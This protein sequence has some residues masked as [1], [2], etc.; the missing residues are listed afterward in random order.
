MNLHNFIK[1]SKAV[2][3]PIVL[4]RPLIWKTS[5]SVLHRHLKL[6]KTSNRLV[7]GRIRSIGPTNEMLF[8]R[9]MKV[10][11]LKD[12]FKHTDSL[13]ERIH[14]KLF[15][16]RNATTAL[17]CFWRVPLIPSQGR[18]QTSDIC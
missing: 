6:L 10:N 4:K 12:L 16:E 3:M 14:S 17:S 18:A 7:K 5:I 2:K 1:S 13:T 11:E 9:S 8:A 15:H